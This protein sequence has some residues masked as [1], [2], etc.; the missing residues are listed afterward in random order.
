MSFLLD[1]CTLYELKEQAH[2][3]DFVCGDRDLDDFF[4]NDCFAYAK[5][6]QHTSQHETY[7]L[8]SSFHHSTITNIHTLY[9]CNSGSLQILTEHPV[10]YL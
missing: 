4:S 1:Y 5:Q 8:R 3:G 10:L 9:I 6:L 2:L 7:V